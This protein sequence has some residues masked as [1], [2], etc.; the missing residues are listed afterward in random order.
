MPPSSAV[1]R[2]PEERRCATKAANGP[3]PFTNYTWVSSI[4]TLATSTVGLLVH[5]PSSN[6][7]LKLRYLDLN[8][9]FNPSEGSKDEKYRYIAYHMKVEINPVRNCRVKY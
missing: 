1:I 5:I 8:K 7:E 3:Q 9:E 2:Y 4:D 6:K